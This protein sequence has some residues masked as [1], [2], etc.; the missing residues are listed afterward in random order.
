[1]GVLMKYLLIILFSISLYPQDMVSVPKGSAKYNWTADS[2]SSVYIPNILYLTGYT[3]LIRTATGDKTHIDYLR[4]W[5]N[6]D[7]VKDSTKGRLRNVDMTPLVTDTV[8][9]DISTIQDNGRWTNSPDSFFTLN[10]YD[11]YFLV[12]S[13]GDTLVSSDGYKLI[14]VEE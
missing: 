4:N 12:S 10:D 13:E 1:M 8:Y 11:V 9:F 3:S 2:V 6:Y 7:G 14:S 5:I